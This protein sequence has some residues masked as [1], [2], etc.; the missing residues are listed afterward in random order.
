MLEKQISVRLGA[1]WYC[2]NSDVQSFVVLLAVGL[3]LVPRCW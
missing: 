1:M 2:Q 3:L